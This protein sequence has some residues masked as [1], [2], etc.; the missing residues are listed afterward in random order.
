MYKAIENGCN[1]FYLLVL[2]VFPVGSL[3][4]IAPIM[5]LNKVCLYPV[6]A[7]ISLVSFG[8]PFIAMPLYFL[9]MFFLLIKVGELKEWAKWRQ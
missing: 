7:L 9:L 5:Y 4:H 2:F 6:H 8:S 1:L 3:F